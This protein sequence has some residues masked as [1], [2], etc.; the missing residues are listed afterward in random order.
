MTRGLPWVRGI[1]W[2]TENWE[3]HA[4]MAMFVRFVCFLI[5]DALQTS[6]LGQSRIMILLFV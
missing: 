2:E 4:D 1:Q 6:H 3:Q 5:E